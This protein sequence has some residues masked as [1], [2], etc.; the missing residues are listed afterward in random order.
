MPE[1]PDLPAFT[2]ILKYAAPLFEHDVIESLFEFVSSSR[3]LVQSERLFLDSIE[4]ARKQEQLAHTLWNH[5]E[6]HPGVLQRD[7]R[8]GHGFAQEDAASVV[9]LWGK[10]G[11]LDRESE[12]RSY[13]LYLHTRLDTE[14]AG[15]CPTCGVRGE[16]RK[17]LFFRPVTCQKCGTE[18]YYHIEYGV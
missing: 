10:L 15:V 11:I 5:L 7:I 12:D 14:M 13:R 9:E 2:T 1:I 6:R 4:A 17:E 16:G 3:V 18:G 8:A